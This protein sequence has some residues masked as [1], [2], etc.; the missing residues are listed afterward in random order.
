MTYKVY[1]KNK[2]QFFL[3]VM[4]YAFYIKKKLQ[5][6]SEINRAFEEYFKEHF[7]YFFKMYKKWEQEESSKVNK[8]IFHH[9]KMR[10]L[11]NNL[12]HKKYEW[13]NVQDFNHLVDLLDNEHIKLS[14][15]TPRFLQKLQEDHLDDKNI[16]PVV[17]ETQKDVS[18]EPIKSESTIGYY[19]ALDSKGSVL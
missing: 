15:F 10:T 7:S 4:I 1:E 12:F 9:K 3:T 11:H 13:D 17:I 18:N 16:E 14:V 2:N 5:S 8:H 19:S 6:D